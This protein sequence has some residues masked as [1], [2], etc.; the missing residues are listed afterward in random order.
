MDLKVAAA[1][2]AL[3]KLSSE[4]A[5]AAASAALDGGAFADALGLLMYTEPIW[6]EVGPLF[7]RALAALGI[8]VPSRQVASVVLAREH[9]RRIVAGEVSPYEGAR[10]I[11]WE[12]ANAP[13]A[14]GSLL[15]FVGWA[16]EW[17]DDPAHRP[18]YEAA[19][20]EE[21]RRLAV[22]SGGV[23]VEHGDAADPP[24]AGR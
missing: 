9:A 12:A 10:E 20:L 23:S 14:D 2:L 11:W 17:E 1:R 22:G 18:Q 15:S 8:P 6:S 24:V 5:I 21:A 4:E 13:G 19:I 3:G 7:E 16:S